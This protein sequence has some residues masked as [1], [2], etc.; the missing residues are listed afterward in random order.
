MPAKRMKPEYV[1]KPQLDETL[2]A[3]LAAQDKRF[4]AT[5]AALGNA[6]LDRMDHLSGR[7]DQLSIDLARHA[8][9]IEEN[10]AALEARSTP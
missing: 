8:K 7:M 1:T 10:L 6:L 5:L 2:A 9:T 3:A 4:D